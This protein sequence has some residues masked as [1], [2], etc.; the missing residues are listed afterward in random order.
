DRKNRGRVVRAADSARDFPAA[1]GADPLAARHAIAD[2]VAIGMEM[3]FHDLFPFSVF[4]WLWNR[5]SVARP[6]A[7]RAIAP[8]ALVYPV[9]DSRVATNRREASCS[10]TWNRSLASAQRTRASRVIPWVAERRS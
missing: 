7:D 2:R 1:L 5:P 4:G 6:A 3:A 8:A 10:Q 9:K